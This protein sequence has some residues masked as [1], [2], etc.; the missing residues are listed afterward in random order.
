MGLWYQDPNTKDWEYTDND[1]YIKFHQ[2]L[3]ELLIWKGEMQFDATMGIDYRSIFNG[4]NFLGSQIDGIISKYKEF[5]KEIKFNL[6]QKSQREVVVNLEFWVNEEGTMK[7]LNANL[8]L[9]G[10]ERVAIR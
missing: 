9:G 1:I 5:F 8:V 2:C 3:Q 6:I 7:T 4:E 10:G